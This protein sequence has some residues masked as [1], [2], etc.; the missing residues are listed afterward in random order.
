M[1]IMTINQ[2]KHEDAMSNLSKTR[3]TS[4]KKS[5]L[6]ALNGEVKPEPLDDDMEEFSA[7]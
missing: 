7:S 5:K 6:S 4:I 1:Y 3:A 2:T